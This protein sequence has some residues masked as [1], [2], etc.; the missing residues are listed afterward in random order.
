MSPFPSLRWIQVNFSTGKCSVSGSSE[1]PVT[2]Q[3][4]PEYSSGLRLLCCGDLT[5]THRPVLLLGEIS[6]RH[7]HFYLPRHWS[8][9]LLPLTSQF[10]VN[11]SSSKSTTLLPRS[12][13]R[14]PWQ[15]ALLSFACFVLRPLV[16]PL[17]ATHF[18]FKVHSGTVPC[19]HVW[20]SHS[21][22]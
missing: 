22:P 12:T 10:P 3:A 8:T 17:T 16:S 11:D 14:F 6:V 13:L 4:V 15:Q 1:V 20:H 9:T 18:P 19:D 2:R 5:V 7:R 21:L